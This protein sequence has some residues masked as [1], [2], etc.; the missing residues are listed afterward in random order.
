MKSVFYSASVIVLALGICSAANAKTIRATEMNAATWSAISGS[1]PQETVIE[2]R[3]GDQ[4]PVTLSA[5]GDLLETNQA[6]AGVIGVKRNF[7]LRIGS[8]GVELSLDGSA[9]KPLS[10]VVSG[11]FQAG[12]GGPDS[13][14]ANAINLALKAYLK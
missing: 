12:A 2:F 7:W 8:R 1:S 10:E 6:S 5:E 3:Q 4:L 11:S 13:G 9:Y 14:V